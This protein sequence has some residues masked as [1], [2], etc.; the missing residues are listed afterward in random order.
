MAARRILSS[1]IFALSL[2]GT[3]AQAVSNF[4]AFTDETTGITFMQTNTSSDY[5]F[6]YG[7]ALPESSSSDVIGRI[8][9]PA[10]CGWAGFSLLTGMTSG[11]LIVAWP[12]NGEVVATLRKAVS[13][14]EQISQSL[15]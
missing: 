15:V 2:A 6:K 8:E 3:R 14:S 12:H 13:V 1:L 9:A 11:L 7:L 4:P 5:G 10:D